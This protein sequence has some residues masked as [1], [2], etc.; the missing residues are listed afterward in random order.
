MRIA[1]RSV[2]ADTLRQGAA[3]RRWK[4]C[5]VRAPWRNVPV[6]FTLAVMKNIVVVLAAAVVPFAVFADELNPSKYFGDMP[7]CVPSRAAMMPK[8]V[9]AQ[10]S[11]SPGEVRIAMTFS[12]EGKIV[13]RVVLASTP[14]GVYDEPAFAALEWLKVSS[15]VGTKSFR[16][17]QMEVVFQFR[18]YD[19]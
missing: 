17:C 19:K 1:N 3:R 18:H 6:T 13:E 16:H 9:Y 7:A 15:D 8:H 4:L 14:A 11:D 12:P 5:T 2:D 10:A